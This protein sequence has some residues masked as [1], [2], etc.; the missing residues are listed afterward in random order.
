MPPKEFLD[1][2]AIVIISVAGG[3]TAITFLLIKLDLLHF[4]KN[5]TSTSK[6][7]LNP[8]QEQKCPLHDSLQVLVSKVKYTQIVN[9][10]LHKDHAEAF[11][12]GERKFRLLQKQVGAL[13]EGV[14]ILMDRSG[15]RPITW[16]RADYFEEE[17]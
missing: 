7:Y 16:K 12:E 4:G 15:G 5:F 13:T 1:A 6:D 10:Q 2:V 11:K 9:T 3:M 17:D 14:G 8:K